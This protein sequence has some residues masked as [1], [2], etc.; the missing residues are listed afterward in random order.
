MQRTTRRLVTGLAALAFSGAAF[1]DD[2]KTRS[3]STTLDDASITA[4]VKTQLIGDADTKAYQINVETRNGVVQLNGFVDSSAAKTEAER[5][6]SEA[7]GV[8]EVRNNLEVRP[9]TRSGGEVI[10]DAAISAKV[11]AALAADS[12]TS[13]LRVDVATREGEVQLS[14]FAKSDA[15]RMAAE[16]VASGVSG[17]RTVKNDLDVR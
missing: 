1:A 4:N 10:D 17:V 11:D 8:R 5:L 13:A 15:E 3:A 2:A 12:R 14:G 9:N 6:A 16:D 7:K